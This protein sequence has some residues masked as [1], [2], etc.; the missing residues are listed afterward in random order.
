MVNKTN[1]WRITAIILI[2]LLLFNGFGMMGS[3]WGG[4][5]FYPNY[6]GMMSL[7]F[8]NPFGLVFGMLTMILAWGIAI[9]ILIVFIKWIIEA[10]GNSQVQV[11]RRGEHGRRN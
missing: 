5:N 11:R 8:D 4:C 7:M 9:I 1:W 6:G 2:V 10:L 3:E